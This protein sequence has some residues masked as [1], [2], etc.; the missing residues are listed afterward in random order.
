M[1][2]KIVVL[3]ATGGCLDLLNLII[4]INRSTPVYEI[5]GLLDDKQDLWGKNLLG[6]PV[7][8]PFSLIADYLEECVFCTGIGSPYNYWRRDQIIDSLGIPAEK[9]ETLVH[10]TSSV[11]ESAQVGRGSVIFQQVCISTNATVGEF[12]LILPQTV[13]NHDTVIR[14]H[15]I[16]TSS[17]SL[18]GNVN[19]GRLCYIGSNSS[20][21]QDL[22]VGDFSQVGM[23]S[24][25]LK[26]IPE[27]QVFVGAPARYLKDV[28]M[29]L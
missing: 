29:N 13:V 3:G 14:D 24:V 11:A 15:T 1:K 2:K 26:D 12:V 7:L 6:Y 5:V 16:I 22:V 4:D 28:E 20:F 21:R 25:V 19:I 8:G 17:V 9:W 23:G 10:P 27:K 18:S